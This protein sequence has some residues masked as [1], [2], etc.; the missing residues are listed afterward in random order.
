MKNLLFVLSIA[1]IYGCQSSTPDIIDDL[2]VGVTKEKLAKIIDSVY[3]NDS[4]LYRFPKA[5]GLPFFSYRSK[6][7][8]FDLPDSVEVLLFTTEDIYTGLVDKII[9]F[10]VTINSI[11]DE[12]IKNVSFNIKSN[13]FDSIE[14]KIKRIYGIPSVKDSNSSSIR[15]YLPDLLGRLDDVYYTKD[16]ELGYYGLDYWMFPS[17]DIVFSKGFY[18]SELRTKHYL[19][20]FVSFQMKE[21]L[22]LE[23]QKESLEKYER[24]YDSIKDISALRLS[25]KEWNKRNIYMHLRHKLGEGKLDTI[26]YYN[27]FRKAYMDSAYNELMNPCNIE[28]LVLNFHEMMEFN[29]PYQK[30]NK[31]DIVVKNFDDCKVRISVTVKDVSSYNWKTFYI[32]EVWFDPF[33]ELYRMNSIQRKF[34]G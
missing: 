12:K 15:V 20:S 33:D 1:A 29:Y 16:I 13:S 3:L 4:T 23:K 28:N 6:T 22:L 24:F 19:A 7:K 18:D 5:E 32:Y 9:F 10:P 26:S 25:E 8:V 11:E 30:Y 21:D 14:N 17:F 31:D 34:L 2:E 27:A